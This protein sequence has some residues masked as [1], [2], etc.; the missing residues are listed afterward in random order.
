VLRKNGSWR[1]EVGKKVVKIIS[2]AIYG[3]DEKDFL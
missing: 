2:N 3:V 1:L